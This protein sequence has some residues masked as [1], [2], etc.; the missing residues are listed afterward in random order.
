M[1]Y[2]KSLHIEGFKKFQTLNVEFNEHMNILVG[3]NEA[4]K[5]T[6]LDAI[7]TVLNQQYRL[8]DKSVLRDLFNAQMVEAFEA[9]PSV[10]TLPRILIEVELVLDPKTKNA[11]YFYGE[12]YGALKKQDEKFGIRFE[13]K[14]DELLGAGMEQSILDKK[15]PYEYY[16][17]TWMTFANNP[18]QTIRKPLQFLAIDITSNATVPSFNSYNRTLFTSRYDEATRAKAKNDFRTK[19]VE[20]FDTTELPELGD[21]RKF[22]VDTKKVVLETILSVYEGAIAL[23]NRGSGMESLIKTEIALEKA[24]GLDVI[25]MEEPENHLSFTTL[26]KML[27]EISIKQK[28]SQIIV[29]THNNMI[30]SRLNLNNVL[31]ITENCVKSLSE[32]DK[33]VAKFFVKADDNAFLQLVQNKHST[34]SV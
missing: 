3:E 32:V 15:I 7:K 22:G 18:Y 11:D 12:V 16:A 20:A 23:E 14:Y 21:N 29:A 31:W 30:A 2:I 28:N 6:I 8:A 24:N 19:L 13:C 4:G 5:S 33:D 26:R 9:N 10:K 25:L 1:N 34:R 27:H 17:L